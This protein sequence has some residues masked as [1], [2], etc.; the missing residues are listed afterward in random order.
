MLELD[1]DH[2]MSLGYGHAIVFFPS[3]VVEKK[4]MPLAILVRDMF[5]ELCPSGTTRV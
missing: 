2:A 3:K 4:V 5:E 1:T